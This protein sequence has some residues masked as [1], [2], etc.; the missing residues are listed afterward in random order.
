[1]ANTISR[2]DKV[3]VRDAFGALVERRAVTGTLM[4]EDFLVVRVCTEEEWAAAA[5]EGR[6]P[7]GTPWP[8]EDVYLAGEEPEVQE[9]L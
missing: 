9:A 7:R 4:G 3:R 1:M 5:A 2:G 8:A 6:E